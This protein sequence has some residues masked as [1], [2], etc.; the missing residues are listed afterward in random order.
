MHSQLIM[1]NHLSALSTEDQCDALLIPK[2]TKIFGD[3]I[4]LESRRIYVVLKQQ[5]GVIL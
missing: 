3:Y 5:C 2:M 4:V 1:S